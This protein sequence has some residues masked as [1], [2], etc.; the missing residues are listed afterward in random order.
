VVDPLQRELANL[1]QKHYQA[2]NVFYVEQGITPQT[3]LKSKVRRT[4]GGTAT[5]S[6]GGDSGSGGLASQALAQTRQA[7]MAAREGCNRLA[8]PPQAGRWALRAPRCRPPDMA[9][10]PGHNTECPRPLPQA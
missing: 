5:G 7:M 9:A 6:G 2:V 8:C 10:T 4:Q 3:D 1:L